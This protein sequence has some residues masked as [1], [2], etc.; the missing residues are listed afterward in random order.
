[1]WQRTCTVSA[2]RPAK[3]I[4]ENVPTKYRKY[5]R[6]LRT[7]RPW[8]SPRWRGTCATSWSAVLPNFASCA[9]PPELQRRQTGTGMR[10][11]FPVPQRLLGPLASGLSP[12]SEGVSSGWRSRSQR[13]TVVWQS[14]KV[15][16]SSNGASPMCQGVATDAS[17]LGGLSLRFQAF[18][19][20]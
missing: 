9:A 13:Y 11:I 18:M 8:R 12:P 2:R 7:V 3:Q 15:S 16:F 4:P 14:R 10:C 20:V 6:G 5:L 17:S 1:M 19:L